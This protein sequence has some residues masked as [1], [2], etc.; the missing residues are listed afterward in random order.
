MRAAILGVAV[1]GSTLRDFVRVSTCITHTDPKAEIGA[2][3]VALAAQMAGQY[4]KVDANHYLNRIEL[5]IGNDDPHFVGLISRVV[6]SV[7]AGQDTEAFADEMGLN[8]GIS[9]YMY[10]SVPVAIHAWLSHQQDC[11]EAIVTV[12]RCGGD[13]DSTGAIVGGIVGAGVGR[14][15]IPEDWLSKLAEWPRTVGWMERLGKQLATAS[16][17]HS[18]SR[19]PRLPVIPLLSRNLFFLFVV[20]CHGLRRLTPPY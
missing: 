15:G 8:K 2:F 7:N 11:R 18:Q 4:T 19:A 12:I 20:L 10:H 9:G 14:S 6:R 13:T 17:L 3:A 16:A 1:G 5:E